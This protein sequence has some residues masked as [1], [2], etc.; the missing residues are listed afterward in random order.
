MNGSPIVDPTITLDP[1]ADPSNDQQ[2]LNWSLSTSTLNGGDTLTLAFQATASVDSGEYDNV[3]WVTTDH[4]YFPCV[5]SGT[6]GRVTVSNVLNIDADAA[7]RGVQTR[8][9]WWKPQGQIDI[10]SWQE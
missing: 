4:D 3:G 5:S 8:V 9:H 1:P 6:S 10:I 7:N 2:T